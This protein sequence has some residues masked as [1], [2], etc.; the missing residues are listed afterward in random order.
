MT[1]L[2]RR[3]LSLLGGASLGALACRGGAAAAPSSPSTADRLSG[4]TLAEASAMIYARQVTST[5]LVKAL[6][7][8][9]QMLNPKVNCYITV[10]AREALAQAAALDAE[11]AGGS[12]RGPLHGIP[13]ALKD[14]I[15][16]AGIRTTAASPMFKDRVPTEDA[17]IVRRLKAAGAVM[18]GKLNLHEFAFGCTGDVS[19]FGPTR[20]PWA[21]DHVTGGSSAGS[22][23]AVAA[24]L[25]YGALG[26]DTGGSIRVPSAWCGIVGFKPTTGLVSI[27]GI[28]PCAASLD[29]CGP[30]ARTVEDVALMLGE[31][32]GYDA[33]D[34][35]SVPSVKEDY[36]KAMRQPV[37]GFRLGAPA[38]FWDHV[39]PEIEGILLAARDKVAAL[40]AGVV[41]NAP[42]WDGDTGGA[43][44]DAAF[45]HHELIE[46]YGLDYMPPDRVWIERMEN[47]PPGSRVETPA[48]VARS[49]QRLMTTR[50]MIDASFKD[51]DLVVVPTTRMAAP[52]INDSLK[53]E[54]G[55]AASRGGGPRTDAKVYDFFTADSGCANTHYFDAYGVPALTVPC[56]FTK[57]GLPVGL[58]IAGPHFAEGKV[59][60]LA[61]AYEQ[62]SPWRKKSPALTAATPVPPIVE[63]APP[64]EGAKPAA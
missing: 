53:R 26:T 42:L 47:P 1:D 34:I 44:G 62:A 51:F 50:R 33:L 29:H 15:D 28:I 46:K 31:M 9:I 36:V 49:K 40:T 11:Q 39:D 64:A 16:T 63:G 25:C 41:S 61:Y 57:A 27:R 18:I 58:M 14:N 56:G 55:S 6:L 21:L 43:D 32:A 45:Y 59:L 38:S 3:D 17:D 2:T 54:M 7:D 20:N 10:T 8:R 13:I 19:Y 30:M 22:G 48:E 24:T 52:K 37:S 35:F 23:A 4:L 60:A 5:E 12:F